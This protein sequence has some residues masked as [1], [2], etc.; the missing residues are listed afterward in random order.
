MKPLKKK[1]N[2]EKKDYETL[3]KV[4]KKYSQIEFEGKKMPLLTSS[5]KK[6]FR[7]L[8]HKSC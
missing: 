4:D 6:G 3:L 5:L 8:I 7:T 1:D 2:E